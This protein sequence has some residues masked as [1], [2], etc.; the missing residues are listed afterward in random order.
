MHS[1][2]IVQVVERTPGRRGARRF[3]CH[4]HST[5]RVGRCSMSDGAAYLLLLRNGP[6]VTAVNIEH[7]EDGW[8]RVHAIRTRIDLAENGDDRDR[9]RSWCVAT[10]PHRGRLG[11]VATA[12][13]KKT[14]ASARAYRLERAAAHRE[15]RYAGRGVSR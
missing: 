13:L 1:R 12:W 2:C 3:V 11:A 7:L 14:D 8:L 6:Q 15:L 10:L 9:P 4:T 5:R